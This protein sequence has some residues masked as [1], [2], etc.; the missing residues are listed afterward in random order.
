MTAA[1]ED[2]AG[3]AFAQGGPQ[4][5]KVGGDRGGQQFHLAAAGLQRLGQPGTQR[6]EVDAVRVREQLR[7]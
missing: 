3:G 6:S 7:G 4:P 2:E 1:D 5:G